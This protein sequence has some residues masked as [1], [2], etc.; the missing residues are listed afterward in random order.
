MRPHRDTIGRLFA[1]L[2]SELENT[3]ELAVEGQNPR[4]SQRQQ[5]TLVKRIRGQLSR[6]GFLLATIEPQTAPPDGEPQ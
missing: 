5:Q 1:R 2:T 6:I 4:L 3:C